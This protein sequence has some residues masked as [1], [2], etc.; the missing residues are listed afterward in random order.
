MARAKSRNSPRGFFPVWAHWWLLNN[1]S[2]IS[3]NLPC[4]PAHW[5]AIAAYREYWCEGNGKSRKRHRSF[6]EAISCSRITGICTV[7]NDAQNGHSKSEYSVTSTGAAAEPS[8]YPRNPSA[9]GVT[10]AAALGGGA[11]GRRAPYHITPPPTTATTAS[12]T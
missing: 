4:S 5:A 7:A 9:V 3:Q 11:A 8:V 12:S 1:W 10:T 2:C 6:P